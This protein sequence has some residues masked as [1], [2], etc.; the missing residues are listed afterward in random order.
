MKQT[1]HFQDFE[2]A[3]EQ[4]RPDNFTSDGLMCLFEYLE[5]CEKDTGEEY[6]LDVIALCCDFSEDSW[7]SI[8]EAYSIEYD[9]NENDDEGQEKV[10]E[11][12]INQGVFVGEVSGGFVYRQH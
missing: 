2:H 11:Y 4:I 8:A 6:E 9:E 3:F 12:L 5:E 1:V 7:Q 10:K